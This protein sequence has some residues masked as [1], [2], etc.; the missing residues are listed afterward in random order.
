MFLHFVGALWESIAPGVADHLW[1]STLFAVA[2]ALLTVAL[3]RNS[4][5]LRY[6]IWLIASLKFM[7]PFSLL[8]AAGRLFSWR[9]APVSPAG[10]MYMVE[11]V[12]QPFTRPLT[13]GAAAVPGQAGPVMLTQLLPLL[14]CVWLLGFLAVLCVWTVRWLRVAKALRNSTVLASGREYAILQ[15]LQEV[16][17]AASSTKLMQS[18]TALEPGIFGILRP[19]L[20]W[21][22]AVS[23]HLDDA[24]LEAVIAHELCHV[25]RRD[26]L[27]AVMH[28]L[29]EAVFWFHPLVW[30]I[31]AQLIA[32]RERACDEAVIEL[33]SHR[34]TYAESILK[35]CEFC[36]SSPLTCVSGVTGSDLKKRMV[37][38]MT[39]RVVRKLNFA[40]KLLLWTAACLAIALPI[41]FG[42]LNVTPTRA[43]SPL[44]SVPKFA[45][46][47]IKPH[48]A[49]NQGFMMQKM[50][51]AP[52]R[53]G[54]GFT[55]RGVSL[56]S[57]L[58]G[59]YMVQ[60]TQI[61]GEPDWAKS[62]KY[63]IDAKADPSFAEQTRNLGDQRD[64]LRAQQMLQ[65]LVTDYFKVS[66]HQEAQDQTV[67]E[68]VVGEGGSKLQRAPE[69]KK[70][71]MMRMGMGELNSEGTPLDLLVAQLS[72]RL[73]RTVVDKTGLKGNYVFNLHWTPD[74][75]EQARIRAAAPGLP[76]PRV[77]KPN[78]SGP[79]LMTAV[80]EQLGLKLQPTTERV[81]IL[82]IDHAEQPAQN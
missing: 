19:V 27:A 16:H 63:D 75:D 76:E 73:R 10:G 68:L 82:V 50:M 29:V 58:R 61:V 67:Y 48:P 15:R 42:L 40:R 23:E 13:T 30:W 11:V 39:D 21:P 37:Q 77:D 3:R 74:A 32:E 52:V 33:G 24:H 69:S 65:Q 49:E 18:K 60:D 59:A 79:P 34:H 38:I 7:V 28:M 2:A 8:V 45:S 1:Q 20:L 55:A 78:A 36:L 26:N 64:R 5:R 57:L 56:H 53:D 22:R 9:H 80:E 25:R 51:M 44:S 81:P 54:G 47:S 72:Q 6:A 4:A 62:E 70:M 43:E 35:V 14:L 17:A 46:V 12:G 31:G 71:A 66:L 41:A